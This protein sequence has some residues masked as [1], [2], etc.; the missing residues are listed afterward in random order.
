[1]P[2]NRGSNRIPNCLVKVRWA[3]NLLEELYLRGWD[4]IRS[5]WVPMTTT[6]ELSPQ[7]VD[8]GHLQ[9]SCLRITTSRNRDISLQLNRVDSCDCDPLP[10]DHLI[11]EVPVHT[12]REVPRYFSCGNG[13]R[14]LLYLK[15]LLIDDTTILWYYHVWV[16]WTLLSSLILVLTLTNPWDTLP[17]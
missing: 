17:R 10:R 4:I 8:V 1:M 2:E 9:L 11:Y 14:E 16:H 15:D 12:Y 7:H 5:H 13:F 3:C 6:Q